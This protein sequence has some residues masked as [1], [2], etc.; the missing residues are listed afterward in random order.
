MDIESAYKDYLYCKSLGIRINENSLKNLLS[1]TAGLGDQGSGSGPP[2]ISVPPNNINYAFLVYNDMKSDNTITIKEAVYSALIRCCCINNK[3][4]NALLLF[5]DMINNN[6][7]P[8]LRTLHPLLTVLSQSNNNNHYN[9]CYQLFEEINLKYNLSP[10]EREYIIMLKLSIISNNKNK[11]FIILH[12]MM[13]E[14]LIVNSS[15]V[16]DV[17]IE[18]FNNN[19]SKNNNINDS[20]NDS[21]NVNNDNNNS[22]NNKN[23]N[24]NNCNNSSVKNGNNNNNK[25]NKN[26]KIIR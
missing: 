3:P 26:I 7:G 17:L 19:N 15:E 12:D 23:N 14:L 8:K 18:F 16:W 24:S 6:I 11:F 10:S 9:T 20:Y 2:R 22:N 4:D 13:E 25:N 21:S 5:N 1:L